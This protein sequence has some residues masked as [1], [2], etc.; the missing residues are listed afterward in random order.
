M[1]LIDQILAQG[2]DSRLYDALVQRTGLT[3]DVSAGIN[4][5]LGNMF[6]YEGPMLWMLAVY[7]DRDKTA[8]SLM[9]VIDGEID[10]L[11]TT[12]VDSA[13]L[14]RA[15]TKM[16]SSLYSIVEEFSGLGKLDLLAAFALFDNDPSKINTLEDGFAAVTPDQIMKTANE[17]LRPGN[18]TVYTVLPGASDRTA[19]GTP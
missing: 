11:R 6:N 8:D 2:R 4:W 5:G 17:W 1:G 13:T 9:K 12:P 19:A 10:A 7:H 15:R 14:E 18:R 3:S 16:R